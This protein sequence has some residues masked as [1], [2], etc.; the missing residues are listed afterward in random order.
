MLFFL[1]AVSTRAWGSNHTWHTVYIKTAGYRT[2]ID[3]IAKDN[4]EQRQ[5]SNNKTL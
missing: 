5:K 2:S 3:R 4:A 1:A